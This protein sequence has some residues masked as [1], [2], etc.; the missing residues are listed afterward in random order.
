LAN[1]TD[2]AVLGGLA[3]LSVVVSPFYLAWLGWLFAKRFKTNVALTIVLVIACGLLLN[4]FIALAG[5]AL[6]ARNAFH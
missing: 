4:G 6:V 1:A 5:C 3:L 2:S